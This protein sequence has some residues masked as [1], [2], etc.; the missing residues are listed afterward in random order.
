MTHR[1]GTVTGVVVPGDGRGRVLG[2]PTANLAVV[3]DELPSDGIYAAW[4][5]VEGGPRVGASVS[6]GSNPTFA[7]ERA[8]RIEV[9]LH[10]VELDLYGRSVSV[11]LVRRLRETRRF[12]RVDELIAQTH[13]DIAASRRALVERDRDARG[14]VVVVGSA[15]LDVV[16]RVDR[17]PAVGETLLGTAGGRFPGGKGLNQATAAARSGADV[18]FCAAVGDDDAG[19]QLMRA[20]VAAGVGVDHVRAV[21]EPTGIAHILSYPDGDN[22]IAVAAGANGALTEAGAAEAV[23]DATVVLVQLEV[24]PA[25]VRGALS[26]AGHAVRI[27]NAAPAREDARELLDLVDI[28]VVNETECESLGGIDTLAAEEIT[29]VVTLGA[30]GVRVHPR[31]AE[32]FHVPAFSIDVVD[33]TGAGDAF[34]GALAA[35]LAQGLELEQAVRRAN[36]AGAIAAC[37]LGAA[38]YRISAATLDDAVE[39]GAIRA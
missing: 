35:S 30:A 29:V 34:C 28:V 27:L 22:S 1:L 8:R 32:A 5:R 6:I 16:V 33:T 39:S 24:P 36:A 12:E 2:F 3:A 18:R 31:G 9:H 7:G 25:A 14:T 19:E 10:D 37:S 20:L 38:A 4:V 23:R 26:A 17:P 15:N 13:R 21:D 11:M